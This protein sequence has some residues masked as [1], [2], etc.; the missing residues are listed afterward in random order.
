M[1]LHYSAACCLL[2]SLVLPFLSSSVLLPTWVWL[3]KCDGEYVTLSEVVAVSGRV[4]H[5]SSASGGKRGKKRKNIREENIIC[6]RK[7]K[8]RKKERKKEKSMK[9]RKKK[10]E[11]RKKERRKRHGL[12][13]RKS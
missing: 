7:Q 1:C 5:D 12:D 6:K 13:H 2:V 9:K 10:K 11:K 8:E 3:L 4:I